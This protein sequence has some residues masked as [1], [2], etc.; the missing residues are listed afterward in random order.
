[1][2]ERPPDIATTKVVG[3]GCRLGGKLPGQRLDGPFRDAAL[4]GS[5][6]RRL[7][8]AILPA[9][10]VVFEFIE[11]NGMVATYSLS[12]IPSVIQT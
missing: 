2:R 5:P 1:M 6:L 9:E 7:G 10:N 8:N 11:A 12:Y 3:D 4:G